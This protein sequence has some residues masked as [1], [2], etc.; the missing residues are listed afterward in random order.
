[1]HADS[2]INSIMSFWRMDAVSICDLILIIGYLLIGLLC[3]IAKVKKSRS[4]AIFIGTTS[5]LNYTLAFGVGRTIHLC[6]CYF[7]GYRIQVIGVLPIYRYNDHFTVLVDMACNLLYFFSMMMFVLI[8]LHSVNTHPSVTVV[9][10]KLDISVK[11]M[12]VIVISVIL[13]IAVVACYLLGFIT[14]NVFIFAS[15]GIFSVLEIILIV[16]WIQFYK[17]IRTVILNTVIPLNVK[18]NQICSANQRCSL[19]IVSLVGRISLQILLSFN[20]V[21]H[22]SSFAL[23]LLYLLFT[24]IT[25]LLAAVIHQLSSIHTSQIFEG[26]FTNLLTS[27]QDVLSV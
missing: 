18:R 24:E 10:E 11:K 14:N 17:S 5:F 4:Q 13:C 23:T 15:A 26:Y 19:Y 12:W 16:K 2:I 7:Y 27:L 25:P 6:L 22:I 20:Y 9:N 3:I 8:C 1:M 21:L